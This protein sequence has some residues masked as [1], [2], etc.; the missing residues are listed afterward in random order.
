MARSVLA[1]EFSEKNKP[2]LLRKVGLWRLGLDQL[3]D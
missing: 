1:D 3:V 2:T